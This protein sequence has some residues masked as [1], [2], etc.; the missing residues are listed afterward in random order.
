MKLL[1][2]ITDQKINLI[3]ETREDGNKNHYIQGVF[4][5]GEDVNQNGR[6]YR[7]PIL[8]KEVERYNKTL[9]ENN[10]AWGELNH[11]SGPSINLDRVCIR[12]V[13]LQREGKDFVGKAIITETPHGEIVKGLL[14]SGG[15]LGVSSRGM[16]TLKEVNG[17]M[18]VQDDFKLATCADVVADPSAHRAFVRSVMENVD[19]V[20]DA[21]SDSWRAAEKLEEQ[22]KA[23]KKMSVKQLDESA[24]NLFQ[25]YMNSLVTK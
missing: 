4:L 20:Y 1:C 23:M 2:E 6:R 16:G 24:L 21:V 15:N 17:I 19:W 22:K 11:P 14:N 10:R 13:S 18:E 5:M 3:K 7:L 12:T 25:K 8:E 9:I